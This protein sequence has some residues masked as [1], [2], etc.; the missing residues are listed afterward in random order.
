M[1]SS[2]QLPLASVS[3]SAFSGCCATGRA[4]RWLS[5]HHEPETE[6]ETESEAVAALSLTCLSGM[7]F[8]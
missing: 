6:T 3:V 2:F 4:A 8:G 1:A 7:S 5:L